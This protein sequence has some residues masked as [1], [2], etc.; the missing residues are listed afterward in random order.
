MNENMEFIL[1][2]L[3]IVGSI[4]GFISKFKPSQI[5]KIPTKLKFYIFWFG[6]SFWSTVFIYII[7]LSIGRYTNFSESYMNRSF[8]VE[9]LTIFVFVIT[10]MLKQYHLNRHAMDVAYDLQRVRQENL[11]SR[12]MIYDLNKDITAKQNENRNF[13]RDLEKL[14]KI[15]FKKYLKRTTYYFWL[16]RIKMILIPT[17]FWIFIIPLANI[18]SWLLV[19]AFFILNVFIS[20]VS[21]YED[22]K[23]ILEFKVT[24]TNKM[25]EKHIE[26]YKT[27]N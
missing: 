27:K 22:V 5:A 16:V 7:I 18:D 2:A 8:V 1:T 17:F 12:S 23:L 14:E 6:C 10:I 3:T 21:F 13:Y 25:N 20:M 24:M 19:I 9:L 4:I 11:K 26:K 15:R